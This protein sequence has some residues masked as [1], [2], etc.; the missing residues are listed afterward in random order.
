MEHIKTSN[1]SILL[2]LEPGEEQ[3]QELL[4]LVE[5]IVSADVVSSG[6]GYSAGDYSLMLL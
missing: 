1:F 6:S 5:Q 2:K 4:Y 3:R